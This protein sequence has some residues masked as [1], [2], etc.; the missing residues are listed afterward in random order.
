MWGNRLGRTIGFPTL[1]L[2]PPPQ[3][4]LPPNGVY[5]SQVRCGAKRY[6]GVSNVGCKPTV[7]ERQEVGVETYLYDFDREA[8]GEDVEV[9]LLAFRR[10]EQKFENLDELKAMLQEDIAAGRKIC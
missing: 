3:K 6:R 1:N 10:P 4:L 2:T 7:S 5:F 8:Y 9:S